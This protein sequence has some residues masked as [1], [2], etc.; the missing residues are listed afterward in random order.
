MNKKG[1]K[2]SRLHWSKIILHFN[3]APYFTLIKYKK[4]VKMKAYKKTMQLARYLSY[5]TNKSPYERERCC[6][7][8]GR[9]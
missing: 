2:N 5:S 3:Y 4:K 1:E 7:A 9:L 8:C 6:S